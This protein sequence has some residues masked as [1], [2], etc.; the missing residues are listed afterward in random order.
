MRVSSVNGGRRWSEEDLEQLRRMAADGVT[1]PEIART[2]G[3]TEAAIE[4]KASQL[5]QKLPR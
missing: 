4:R 3:R 5:R 1:L 2:Q